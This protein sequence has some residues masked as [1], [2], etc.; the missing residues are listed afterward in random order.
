MAAASTPGP[1]RERVGPTLVCA[2]RAVHVLIAE[3]GAW[4]VALEQVLE[5]RLRVTLVASLTDRPTDSTSSLEGFGAIV[6]GEHAPLEERIAQCRRLRDEGYGGAVIAICV[7]ATEGEALLDAGADDFAL[8]PAEARELVTRVVAS[9]RRAA[10]TSR[11]R[12]GALELDRVERE[13]RVHGRHVALTTRECE[14][15]GCLLE[16]RGAVVSPATLRE[17]VWQRKDDRRS[18]LVEVHLS[19]LRDKLG[20]D[21]RMIETVRRAGY[22]LR[23]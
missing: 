9:A 23:R 10:T 13:V 15:L 1:S 17:R 19:R 11:L 5:P 18:N 7:D 2:A 21:A 6:L 8:A 20:E 14:M 12:W 4:G 22:R 16:A 3:R